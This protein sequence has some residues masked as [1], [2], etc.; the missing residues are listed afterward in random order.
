MASDLTRS[1][2]KL[3]ANFRAC[4]ERAWGIGER[5]ELTPPGV[6]H[7]AQRSDA[8]CGLLRALVFR[9][10]DGGFV[11]GGPTTGSSEIN[12]GESMNLFA[13]S[14]SLAAAGVSKRR[15]DNTLRIFASAQVPEISAGALDSSGQFHSLSEQL[16]EEQGVTKFGAW[17]CE[18]WVVF[19]ATFDDARF[20]ALGTKVEGD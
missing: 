11:E 7:E 9:F 19:G 20:V 8:S 18:E 6:K 5:G 10:A 2:V 16:M 3:R 1:G 13:D 14:W 15:V 12:V 17:A 4:F